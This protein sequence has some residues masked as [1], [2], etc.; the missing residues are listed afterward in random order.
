MQAMVWAK[1]KTTTTIIVS[2]VFAVVDL[3]SVFCNAAAAEATLPPYAVVLERVA[4][5]LV[6]TVKGLFLFCFL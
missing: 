5:V 4:V 1:K 2:F 3:L 6:L